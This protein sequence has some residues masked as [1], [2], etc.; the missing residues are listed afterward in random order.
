[1][2]E[3]QNRIDRILPTMLLLAGLVLS[4][5]S[6]AVGRVGLDDQPGFGLTEI[7]VLASGLSLSL[8]SWWFL[9]SANV[10]NRWIWPVTL[11]SL[12]VVGVGIRLVEV[13]YDRFDY[14]EYDLMLNVR[15]SFADYSKGLVGKDE[16]QYVLHYWLSYRLLG[17]GS[18]A[19]RTMS[20]IAG[21][22]LLLLTPLWLTRFWPAQKNVTLVALLLLILNENALYLSR[23]ALFSYGSSF[24][25]ATG[26]F[27]LFLRLVEGPLANRQWLWIGAILLPAALFSQVVMIVPLAIGGLSVIVFRW[28]QFT[29]SRNLEGLGRWVWELKPLLALPLILLIRQMIFPFD[30][31]GVGEL[32]VIEHLF[33]PTSGYPHS[34]L[35]MISFVLTKTYAL[36][37]ALL[38]PAGAQ[39]VS[40]MGPLFL[41]F[42]GFLAALALVPV[43]RRHADR[44][45]LFTAFFLLATLTAT[46][47]GGLLGICPYGSV[48]YAS[49]LTMP[50][51]VLIGIGGSLAHRWIFGGLG[52]PLSWNTLVA[53]LAALSLIG[54]ICLGITRYSYIVSVETSND[55]AISWLRSQQP[56]LVLADNYI[57]AVLYSRAPEIYERVHRLGW[58]A[59]LGEEVLPSER[60]DVITGAEE[61]Q[62]VETILVVLFPH[63]FRETDHYRGFAQKYPRSSRLIEANFD[64]EAS[65][66]GFH[67]QG[68]LYRRK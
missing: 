51:V 42:C 49:Y 65:V 20:L 47:I 33:F 9:R 67:I 21:I 63:E 37:W 57:A 48:R 6:V 19:F 8:I 54:G 39:S 2:T 43:A 24:L 7:L 55:Q 53:N 13:T 44:R 12:L 61:P 23:Y 10:D 5:L 45:T 3:S 11:T 59:W 26:L 32:A 38:A 15:Q 18:N 25:L 58:G 31:S 52:L 4:G 17:E 60:A 56:D 34:L 41:A 46:I 16:L 66:E 22:A 28:W 62:T 30:Y 40:F 1:M 29:E 50:C 36:F 64:L 27:F 14:D 68:L 35:G